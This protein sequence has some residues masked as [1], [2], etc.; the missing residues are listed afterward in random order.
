[1]ADPS[2]A[3][4]CLKNASTLA[5]AKVWLACPGPPLV[6]TY[7]RSQAFNQPMVAITVLIV[8]DGATSGSVI[9]KN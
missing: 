2:P 8:M 7:I 5:M 1:M 3:S 4:F 9:L 6:I